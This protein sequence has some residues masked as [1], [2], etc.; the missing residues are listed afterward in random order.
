MSLILFIEYQIFVGI[1]I[2]HGSHILGW[3]GKSGKM[4]FRIIVQQPWMFSIIPIHQ[5]LYLFPPRFLFQQVKK[6]EGQIGNLSDNQLKNDERHIRMKEENG[7]L[8]ER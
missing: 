6:L 8:I 4:K 3:S 7:F 5:D 1:P 2:F